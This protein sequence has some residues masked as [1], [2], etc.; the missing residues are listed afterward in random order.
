LPGGS[1]GSRYICHFYLA[2]NYKIANN[3]TATEARK[4]KDRFGSLEY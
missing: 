3:S 4:H 2:K 1:M